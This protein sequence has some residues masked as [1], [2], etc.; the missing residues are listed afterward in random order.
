[1]SKIVLE[2]RIYIKLKRNIK[3]I[4]IKLILLARILYVI[5]IVEDDNSNDIFVEADR[6]M[7]TQLISN[8]LQSNAIR[9]TNK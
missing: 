3:D 7:L 9:F 4:K 1:M 5:I 8:N 6:D 2:D